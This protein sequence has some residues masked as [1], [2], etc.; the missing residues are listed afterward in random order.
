MERIQRLDAPYL[1]K[2]PKIT[3]VFEKLRLSERRGLGFLIY[4]EDIVLSET[5]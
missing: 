3:Y 1:S 2:N 5:L 4:T